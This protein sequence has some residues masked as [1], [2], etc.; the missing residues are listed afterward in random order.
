M[1]SGSSLEVINI[2]KGSMVRAAIV[3]HEHHTMAEKH[4]QHNQLLA[5]DIAKSLF[6]LKYKVS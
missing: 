1:I 5:N 6:E 2:D 4:A 3:N